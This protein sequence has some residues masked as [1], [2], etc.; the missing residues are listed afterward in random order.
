MP[1]NDSN[2]EDKVSNLFNTP[3]AFQGIKKFDLARQ[4][5]E[6]LSKLQIVEDDICKRKNLK[7]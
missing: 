5:K 6:F 4:K 2:N 7:S 3:I 1:K